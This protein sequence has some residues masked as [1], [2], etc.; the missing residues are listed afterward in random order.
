MYN[1]T[2]GSLRYVLRGKMICYFGTLFNVYVICMRYQVL[3][4][5]PLM[6]YL[7]CMFYY[8]N[9][10]LLGG[11]RVFLTSHGTL[12]TLRALSF[13]GTTLP[14]SSMACHKGGLH[15]GSCHDLIFSGHATFVMLSVFCQW[16]V[17]R[18][19]TPKWVIWV[20]SLVV[21]VTD[22]LIVAS[23]NHYTVDVSSLSTIALY[24]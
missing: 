20:E 6:G 10:R 14:D 3:Y 24:G 19:V 12:L 9:E 5:L 16:L 1:D 11:L 4:L 15:I 21:I 8:R 2:D 17:F 18:D 7:A 23:R 22:A 13:V